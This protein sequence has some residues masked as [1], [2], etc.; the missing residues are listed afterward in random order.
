MAEAKKSV[1]KKGSDTK[2]KAVD[3]SRACINRLLAILLDSIP[4]YDSNRP[5]I[6]KNIFYDYCSQWNPAHTFGDTETSLVSSGERGVSRYIP[7]FYET[8]FKEFLNTFRERVYPELADPAETAGQFLNV[9]DLSYDPQHSRTLS[10]Y[11][12]KALAQDIDAFTPEQRSDFMANMLYFFMYKPRYSLKTGKAAPPP[13]F[14]RG[15]KIGTTCPFFC[16]REEET[17][18]THKLLTENGYAFITGHSGYGKS[19]LGRGMAVKYSQLYPGY[20]NHAFIVPFHESFR[21][22][23]IRLSCTDDA[24]IQKEYNSDRKQLFSSL[25]KHPDLALILQNELKALQDRRD[26]DLFAAH[27][28]LLA[29]LTPNDLM[30]IDGA[31]LPSDQDPLLA[32]ILSYPCHVLITSQYNYSDYAH[33]DLTGIPKSK[34]LKRLVTCYWTDAKEHV[35]QTKEMIS[36]LHGHTLMIILCAKLL[37]TG[38]IL[39]DDLL[40][41]LRAHRAMLN[42]EDKIKIRKDG[43]DIADSFQ[44]FIRMLFPFFHLDQEEQY[45]LTNLA[46]FPSDGIRLADFKEWVG[47]TG[48]DTD[49]DFRVRYADAI[50]RLVEKG[51]IQNRDG[52]LSMNALIQDVVLAE[53]EVAPSVIRCHSLLSH[54]QK[55]CQE[56]CDSIEYPETVFRVLMNTIILAQKDDD[57]FYLELMQDAFFA[58][59]FHGFQEGISAISEELSRTLISP[60]RILTSPRSQMLHYIKACNAKTTEEERAEYH[61]IMARF[62]VLPVESLLTPQVA[63]AF[64]LLFKMGIS[65]FSGF[66]HE[67]TPERNAT[68]KQTIQKELH[69]LFHTLDGWK[70]YTKLMADILNML[71]W[72]AMAV[73]QGIPSGI[74]IGQIVRIVDPDPL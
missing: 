39:I 20:Y 30:I 58:V 51:L 59:V 44:G 33:L 32:H 35:A 7:P 60:Q 28:R 64:K 49:S 34:D 24:E 14:I 22:T 16:G 67:I 47:L 66:Q 23:I 73:K 65:S 40:D 26:E 70:E 72:V 56:F 10:S 1:V 62:Y 71:S 15:Y 8:H 19:E 21:E 46:L 25:G 4:K 45:I 74:T 29:S 50:F 48:P 6:L 2:P 57:D 36:L 11:R 38:S 61:A 63:P 31:N 42:A 3:H 52:M 69:S 53:E 41:K 27:D 55:F 18:I 68:L 43:A 54:L 9:I 12:K 17:I 5:E 37:D 13:E